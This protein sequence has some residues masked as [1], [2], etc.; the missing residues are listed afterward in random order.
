MKNLIW[1]VVVAGVAVA[2]YVLFGK[3][4]GEDIVEEAPVAA[5]EKPA[6]VVEEKA[7]EAA[8]AVTD[9]VEELKDKA[10]SVVEEAEAKAEEAM[11][12]VKEEA[13]A[14]VSDAKEKAEEMASDA[15]EKVTD[16]TV[17]VADATEGTAM[18]AVDF[19]SAENFSMEKVS[20]LISGSDLDALQ[21]TALAKAVEAAQ[22]NPD[23]LQAALD[24]VKDAL[25]L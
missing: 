8:D 6:E 4:S 15:M 9:A 25:G 22:N 16:A 2:G 13:E 5:V 3:S 17:G 21:K 7:E 20:E 19:L 23:L 10:E 12:A 18:S 14:A 1:V 11:D 24:K